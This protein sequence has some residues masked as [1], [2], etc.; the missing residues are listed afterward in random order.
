MAFFAFF[1]LLYA[2][3]ARP[4]GDST[5]TRPNDMPIPHPARA[6]HRLAPHAA[7]RRLAP[8]GRGSIA[9]TNTLLEHLDKRHGRARPPCDSALPLDICD[10][11]SSGFIRAYNSKPNKDGTLL[12]RP[13]HPLQLH[14]GSSAPLLFMRAGI[15]KLSPSV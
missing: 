14:R 12:R 10:C 5:G 6:A 4:R 13:P 9:A 1:G 8:N 7:P 3:F 2:H 15:A 11:Q